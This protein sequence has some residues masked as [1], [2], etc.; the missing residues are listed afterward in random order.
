MPLPVSNPLAIKAI[1]SS[2]G[3]SNA[4]TGQVTGNFKAGSC[5]VFRSS[6]FEMREAVL[7]HKRTEASLALQGSEKKSVGDSAHS[8]AFRAAPV[9]YTCLMSGTRKMSG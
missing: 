7:N 8:L 5:M 4:H 2:K 9:A 3:D 6:L 1:G